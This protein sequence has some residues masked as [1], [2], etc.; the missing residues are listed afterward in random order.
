MPEQG[1]KPINHERT[2]RAA[3]EEFRSTSYVKNCRKP[4]GTFIFTAVAA[5]VAVAVRVAVE[6]AVA[7]AAL[8]FARL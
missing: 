2:L 3:F 4:F 5:T 8:F 6:V 7:A 1:S